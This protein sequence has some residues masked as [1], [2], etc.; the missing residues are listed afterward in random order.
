MF[1]RRAHS[2]G[3]RRAV[4]LTARRQLHPRL[5]DDAAVVFR[6]AAKHLFRS[7]PVLGFRSNRDKAVPAAS[8]DELMIRM[9]PVKTPHFTVASRTGSP[10]TMMTPAYTAPMATRRFVRC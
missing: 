7:R 10:G 3:R 1:R 2:S 4:G 6:A 9:A 5:I 8:Q